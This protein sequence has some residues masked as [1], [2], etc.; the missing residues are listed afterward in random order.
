MSPDFT[1]SCQE[2]CLFHAVSVSRILETPKLVGGSDLISDP[3]LAMC[4]FHS[5][6]VISR[7]GQHP[8]GH[9][10]QVELVARLTACAEA[11]EE[12]AAIFPT[13]AILKKGI[14]DL[15]SDAQRN[16]GR[17]QA[18]PSIWED[19][20]NESIQT[21]RSVM[22]H[23][24]ESERREIYSKHSVTDIVRSLHFESRDQDEDTTRAQMAP[25]LSEES[26][27]MPT[28]A[29][30]SITTGQY[31]QMDIT[32]NVSEPLNPDSGEFSSDSR[33]V[34][35]YE[36]NFLTLGFDPRYGSGQ[37]DLFMDSFW[38]VTDGD[39]MMPDVNNG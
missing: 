4:A 23:N 30:N 33:E 26:R 21:T 27:P 32:S 37:P 18:Y 10:P 36:D 3:S 14:Q 34:V 8:M 5:A 6:R 19:E 31:V 38:P 29:S 20:E 28:V 35:E 1:T 12:Q 2:K 15:V 11:L 39:W 9:M 13:T 7:L 24:G 22:N 16:R 17:A 25:I